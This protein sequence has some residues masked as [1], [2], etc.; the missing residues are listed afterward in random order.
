MLADFIKTSR[1]NKELEMALSV[2]KDFKKCESI[3]EF[4]NDVLVS[5]QKL[6]MLEKMLETI[7]N[8]RKV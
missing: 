1:T 5:W 4:M 2:I 3:E 7:I 6:E 8:E